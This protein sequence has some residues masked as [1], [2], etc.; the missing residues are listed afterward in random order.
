MRT[1]PLRTAGKSTWRTTSPPSKRETC[2]YTSLARSINRSHCW[3]STKAGGDNCLRS[4]WFG[5]RLRCQNTRMGH[6]ISSLQFSNVC[7][8]MLRQSLNSSLTGCRPIDLESLFHGLRKRCAGDNDLKVCG[9]GRKQARQRIRIC[10]TLAR[11]VMD[12]KVKWRMLGCPTLLQG[13]KLSRWQVAKRVIVCEDNAFVAKQVFAK[14]ISHS[15]F[16]RKKL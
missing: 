13:S 14:F 10:V 12:F 8:Q 4:S 7:W 15:P 3:R 6:R 9:S 5:Y 2:W 1:L 16:Y 11:T